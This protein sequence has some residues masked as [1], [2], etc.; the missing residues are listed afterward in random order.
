MDL[1]YAE[2]EFDQTGALVTPGQVDAAAGAMR[3]AGA[4]DVLVLTHGWNNT[5]DQARALYTNLVAS[6]VA[7]QPQVARAAGRTF[8]VVGV[9]WPSIQ[10]TPPDQPAG[11]G[12]GLGDPTDALT[13]LIALQVDDVALRA[14]LQALAPQLDG[15]TTAR[16]SF[17]AL[18]R[19]ALPAGA[20]DDADPDSAPQA[21]ATA[22]PETV[23]DAAGASGGLLGTGVAQGGGDGLGFDLG[24]ILGKA[25]MV[26]NV[27]TYYTMKQRAGVVGE[28]GIAPLLASLHAAAPTVRLNL[29]GHSFGGRAVTA[30]A[31]ATTAPVSSLN[32]LQAAYSQYGMAEN[33]DGAGSDGVFCQVPGRTP[34]PVLVT[35][36]SND[37]AV[38]LAYPIASRLAGQVGAGLG[39]ATDKY[40]GI[41]RNGALKTPA[42][43]PVMPM[44]DVGGGYSFQPGKVS[45]LDSSRY[46]AG[47]SD[48]T[49]PQVG[50]A[51]LT[52]VTTTG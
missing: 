47:H 8:G 26:L 50:Y 9:I 10:W 33:W 25:C 38:G 12:A 27:F 30:A 49:G 34:G 20:V 15:S 46:I 4:T 32:L 35:F 1:P 43:L 45:S 24:D 51:V 42:E 18:L 17:V 29:V 28:Q 2:V 44:T 21:L 14:R 11:G 7:V 22:D 52:A 39:D 36:S 6:L 40:G 37:R 3:T 41:G 16:A 31:L 13:S 23:F 19:E 48:I 5:P